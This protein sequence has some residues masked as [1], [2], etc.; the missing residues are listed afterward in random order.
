MKKYFTKILN[1]LARRILFVELYNH[2]VEMSNLCMCLNLLKQN[3]VK[4]S[5]DYISPTIE[6]EQYEFKF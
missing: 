3:Q 6:R 2:K 4:Q 1:K 5:D